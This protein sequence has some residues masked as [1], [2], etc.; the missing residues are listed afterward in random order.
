MDNVPLIT[1]GD[2]ITALDDNKRLFANSNPIFTSRP[3]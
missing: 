3:N 1:D 2:T